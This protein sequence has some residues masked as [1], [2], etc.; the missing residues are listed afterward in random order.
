MKTIIIM[1]AGALALTGCGGGTL[2]CDSER[3]LTAAGVMYENDIKEWGRYYR[4]F[5]VGARQG[6][7]IKLVDGRANPEYE[8]SC[9]KHSCGCLAT[10]RATLYP[11][12][13]VVEPSE[14]AMFYWALER[15]DDPNS[16]FS[17]IRGNLPTEL[18]RAVVN[19]PP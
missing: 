9:K 6:V 2:D 4:G 10:V 16:P 18:K 8:A 5:R 14:P 7:Q 12:G 11:S 3:V 1:L 15:P 13:D 17:D 19:D